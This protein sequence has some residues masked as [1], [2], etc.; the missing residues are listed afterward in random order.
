[1]SFSAYLQTSSQST[2]RRT[3]PP[4][5]R[6]LFPEHVLEKKSPPKE[7]DGLWTTIAPIRTINAPTYKTNVYAGQAFILT[8][9]FTFSDEIFHLF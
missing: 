9:Y 3:T 7:I 4:A 5:R 1:M 8:K 2:V 6:S